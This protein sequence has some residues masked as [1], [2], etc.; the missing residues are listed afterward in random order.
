MYKKFEK[1]LGGN[2]LYG[3]KVYNWSS[4]MFSLDYHKNLGYWYSKNESNIY[5]NGEEIDDYAKKDGVMSFDIV[6]IDIDSFEIIW[7]YYAKDKNNVYYIQEYNRNIDFLLFEDANSESFKVLSDYF[8]VDDSSVY[9]YMGVYN[10]SYD[11]IGVRVKELYIN[12]GS[13][14]VLSDW[15]AKNKNNVYFSTTYAMFPKLTLIEWVDVNSFTYIWNWFAR[16]NNFIYRNSLKL[17]KIDKNSFEVLSDYYSKDKNSI[18]WNGYK[19]ENIDV[20]SFII[21]WSWF[22]KDKNYVFNDNNIQEW[23]NISS[24]IILWKFFAKDKNNFYYIH[25]YS[26]WRTEL[27]IIEWIYWEVWGKDELKIIDSFNK[28]SFKILWKYYAKDSKNIYLLSLKN[29]IWLYIIKW[30]DIKTFEVL[31][32]NYSKDKS[33]VYFQEKIIEWANPKNFNELPVWNCI[34]SYWEDQNNLYYFNHKI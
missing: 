14:K 9:F 8:S 6:D 1:L 20:N 23:V 15:Y 21:L 28:E 30:I 27:K 7:K 4:I 25:H 33:N 29:S 18:Y 11:V 17:E 2:I 24:F 16:D 3:N 22:A 10:Y 32:D 31:W 12:V 13:F 19:L 34:W 26:S 5:Y